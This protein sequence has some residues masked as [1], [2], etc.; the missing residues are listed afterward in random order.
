MLVEGMRRNVAPSKL[1]QLDTATRFRSQR[2][3][4]N[5]FRSTVGNTPTGNLEVSR[6]GRPFGWYLNQKEY[7]PIE[8]EPI[9]FHLL[10]APGFR[11]KAKSISSDRQK[12]TFKK[13]LHF[14][15]WKHRC[16]FPID[17]K[18]L[19]ETRA[20]ERTHCQWPHNRQQSAMG[21]GLLRSSSTDFSISGKLVSDSRCSPRIAQ[22]SSDGT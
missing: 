11:S 1:L 16:L 10:K 4:L 2:R 13:Y 7:L 19:P 3:Q 20:R 9:S 21:S 14:G 5:V 18:P 15:K 12:L 22:G 8:R 6:N 17:S